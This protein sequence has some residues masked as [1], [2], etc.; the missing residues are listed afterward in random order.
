MAGVNSFGYSGTNAHAVLQEAP[1][2]KNGAATLERPCEIVFLSAKSTGSLEDMVDDWTNMLA[3]ESADSLR[4]MLIPRQW[5]EHICD[6]GL[7]SSAVAKQRFAKSS[8]HSAKAV[9]RAA[10]LLGRQP[11]KGNGKS[12]SFLTGQ[13]AQYP[14]MGRQLYRM[15]PVFKNALDRC[16]AVMDAEMGASLNDVLFGPSSAEFLND[17]RYVQPAL[18]A[19]EYALA[20]LLKHWGIE[21]EYVIG[22]SVGEITAACVAGMLDLEDAVRFVVARGR[23]MGQLPRGGK[24]LAVEAPFEEALSWVQGKEADI[25]V[26]AVNAPAGVVLSGKAEA[27]DQ[28][29]QLVAAA[30]RRSKELEV[31]HAF[32][33]PLMEPILEELSSVAA[34]LRVMPPKIPIVSNVTG[35]LHNG[36]LSNGYWSAHVRQ[37]VFF[38][39]GMQTLIDAGCSLLIEVGP[40][41]ALT[42]SVSAAF[43]AANTRCVPTLKR[44]RQ[45]FAHMFE[46]LAALHVVGCPLK[47]A[48]IFESPDYHRVPLPLYPFRRDRHWLQIDPACRKADRH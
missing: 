17:T 5:A 6:T 16:A 36:S 28:V 25:S 2:S 10:C 33:S 19:I 8:G 20:D 14:Q 32:H 37:P 41:P 15:E 11:S 46:M 43:D 34:S 45:D 13:G 47:L 40:Q 9:F 27:I 39:Q 23:L 7:R 12:R 4:D 3:S 18:F 21:P 42:Q 22:H 48:R 29:A 26:A 24:M 31:S 38:Y 1:L 30:N 35:Q 44:D